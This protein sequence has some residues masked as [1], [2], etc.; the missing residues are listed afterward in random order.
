MTTADDFARLISRTPGVRGGRPCVA[1]TG[2]SVQ[3]VV[4][5]YRLGL[6][7]EEI[8]AKFGHIG[9]AEIHTALAYYHASR[10]EIDTALDAEQ[11]DAERTGENDTGRA[12][13]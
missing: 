3:R 11:S 5:W 1:D 10:D 6:S 12:A 13:A 2:V 9:L 8:A 7:P 4:A